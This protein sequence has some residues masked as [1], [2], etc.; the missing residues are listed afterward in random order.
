MLRDA[1]AKLDTEL[2]F[3]VLPVECVEFMRERG[4]PDDIIEDLRHCALPD[5]QRIGP[6]SLV[7]MPDIINQNTNSIVQCIDNGCL[8]LAGGA[9]GDPVVLDRQSRQMLFVSADLLG[10]DECSEFRECV[11]PTPFFYDDFWKA[12]VSDAKF[13]WDYYEAQRQWPTP[14]G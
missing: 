10:S 13:P 7:P 14:D 2:P 8:A 12:V 3:V 1:L 4:I 5:W 6:L 9:N 11:H